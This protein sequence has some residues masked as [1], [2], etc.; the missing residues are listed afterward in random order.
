LNDLPK[1]HAW[2]LV[3]N[4]KN[5][6]CAVFH[7]EIGAAQDLAFEKGNGS[8]V[9][10]IADRGAEPDTGSALIYIAEPREFMIRNPKG[11]DMHHA[12]GQTS[13]MM[14]ADRLG[15]GHKV[16]RLGRDLRETGIV[17]YESR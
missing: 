2:Y 17:V 8:V 9:I 3:L 13:C 16:Y 7:H 15:P 14:A 5:E 12:P 4:A 10:S 1:R 6:E 11:Q